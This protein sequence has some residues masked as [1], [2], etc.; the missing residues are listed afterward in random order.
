MS[1]YASLGVG[2]ST[3]KMI[4]GTS[5]S[6]AQAHT[7]WFSYFSKENSRGWESPEALQYD[8]ITIPMS[9]YDIIMILLIILSSQITKTRPQSIHHMQSTVFSESLSPVVQSAAKFDWQL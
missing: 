6:K 3:E 2:I 7:S 1:R 8:I 5:L 9:Q 4:L